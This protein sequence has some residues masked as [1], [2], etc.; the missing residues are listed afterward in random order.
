MGEPT[1]PNGCRIWY[2]R[3]TTLG[4]MIEVLHTNRGREKERETN[5][6]CDCR[7]EGAE[8][9][10]PLTIKPCWVCHES[11]N[12][13]ISMFLSSSIHS[14][15][16]INESKPDP[17]FQPERNESTEKNK[18]DNNHIARIF[19]MPFGCDCRDKRSSV[20][21]CVFVCY[22]GSNYFVC[23]FFFFFVSS[24]TVMLLCQKVISCRYRF[25]HIVAAVVV[26]LFPVKEFWYCCECVSVLVIINVC[27]CVCVSAG[28][29]SPC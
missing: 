19:L 14:L 7:W 20:C 12:I 16:K 9:K 27:I 24:S 28:F 25:C 29:S 4:K 6:W 15:R 21:V 10:P 11:N 8:E 2:E 1:T 23:F 17:V 3:L 22:F 18:N 5:Y 26:L 13:R